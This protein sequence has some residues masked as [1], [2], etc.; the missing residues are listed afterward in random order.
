MADKWIQKADKKM[1]AKGTKGSFGK[2]TEKKIAAAKRE[3]G[4]E[5]KKAVFAQNMKKIAKEHKKDGG[6]RKEGPR[7][8]GMRHK[9]SARHHS[10]I[11]E[12]EGGMYKGK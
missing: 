4:A 10:P 8:I 2:A 3:G 7:K 12:H 9:F 6:S 5:K 1:E 11:G